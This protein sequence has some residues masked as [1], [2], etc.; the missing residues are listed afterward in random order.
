M[1]KLVSIL[2]AAVMLVSLMTC[3]VTCGAQ[4]GNLIY[5]DFENDK[6]EPWKPHEGQYASL[7]S[8]S[9][10]GNGAV[11]VVSNG[12]NYGETLSAEGNKTYLYS[13]WVKPVQNN[14]RIAPSIKNLKATQKLNDVWCDADGN[15][16]DYWVYDGTGNT[17]YF[18]NDKWTLL[19]AVITT[20]AD[21]SEMEL[22]FSA[23]DPGTQWSQNT[24]RKYYID[25][26]YFGEIVPAGVIL[27]NDVISSSPLTQTLTYSAVIGNS[28]GGTAGVTCSDLTVSDFTLDG[29]YSDKGVT[30]DNGTLT[31][32]SNRSEK[33]YTIKLKAAVSGTVNGETVTYNAVKNITVDPYVHYKN[34]LKN[35][36]FES[37]D[38]HPWL[39][40]GGNLSAYEKAKDGNS[41]ENALDGDWSL[42]VSAGEVWQD[43]DV[44][45]DTYYIMGANFKP[46]ANGDARMD[47]TVHDYSVESGSGYWLVDSAGAEND[48]YSYSADSWHFKEH[49][50]KTT[51][52]TTKV[53]YRLCAR[54]TSGA[55]TKDYYIDNLFLSEFGV[56]GEISGLSAVN[57]GVNNKTYSYS[58]EI[59]N[60]AG[61]TKGIGT[62]TNAWSLKEAYEGVS[63]DKDG[64]LTVEPA[65]K[66]GEV[67]IVLET[68]GTTSADA[69]SQDYTV[70]AEKTVEISAYN[71]YE[72]FLVNPGFEEGTTDGW[73]ASD[74]VI[75]A[76]TD[77]KN[78]GTYSAYVSQWAITQR[79]P[80]KP[81]TVYVFSGYINPSANGQIMCTNIWDDT[82]GNGG[83]YGNWALDKWWTYNTGWNKI[84]YL[85]KTTANT[86]ELMMKI[87]S[88]GVNDWNST[89]PYGV[90]DVY[91]SEFG[92]KGVI[93]GDDSITAGGSSKTYTADVTNTLGNTDYLSNI[94]KTW[95]LKEAYSGVS[96]NSETGE[97]TVAE[98]AQAESVTIVLTSTASANVNIS[99]LV[100]NRGTADE[101]LTSQ[102]EKTV[103]VSNGVTVS[104][105]KISVDFSERSAVSNGTYIVALYDGNKLVSTAVKTDKT[106]EVPYSGTAADTAKVFVWDS[107]AGLKPVIPA[108]TVN[109]A[110]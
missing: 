64:V 71:P 57:A 17:A 31:V 22:A 36:D 62:Y 95:S 2:T 77:D 4:T 55:I 46:G 74:S 93:S 78:S 56:D 52:N 45:P 47:R 10:S 9:H 97:L 58:A 83:K 23:Y 68:T 34:H 88:Y 18:S 100:G 80:V 37:G 27:G 92:V 13:A 98:G 82:I 89:A 94:T 7:T 84:E 38:T 41:E 81:N 90:D 24:V 91:F 107:L 12:L 26:V 29:D 72:N 5:G 50:F 105:G 14:M 60:N 99:D 53:Q 102:T 109:I 21:A 70:T 79:V 20:P 48:L 3:T 59:L 39:E 30:F 35:S 87:N 66:S 103:A 25:D 85:V 54:D 110:N 11:I 15:P 42:Y 101:I 44:L 8:Y 28:Q 1:K 106:F 43:V 40:Y 86:N 108:I 16:I 6:I 19:E 104:D 75:T 65:A 51:E 73:K 32:P 49:I 96:I 61:G 67:T 69:G 33:S 63:I 76:Q